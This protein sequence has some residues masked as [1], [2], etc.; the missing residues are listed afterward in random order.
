M[1]DCVWCITRMRY[2]QMLVHCDG[3]QQRRVFYALSREVYAPCREED[4]ASVSPSV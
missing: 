2:L 3:D 1:L 4:L